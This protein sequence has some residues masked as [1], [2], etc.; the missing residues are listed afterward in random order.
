MGQKQSRVRSKQRGKQ[1]YQ[2]DQMLQQ[3]QY[4]PASMGA[5]PG[6]Y[7]QM[8]GF[9]GGSQDF[10]GGMP[11]YGNQ[12]GNNFYERGPFDYPAAIDYEDM[13][14][15]YTYRSPGPGYGGNIDYYDVGDYGSGGE[16]IPV[17]Q[18]SYYPQGQ[19]Y[20][21]QRP[22]AM[23][24]RMN[25]MK[26]G[27]YSGIG[28]V[29]RNPNLVEKGQMLKQSGKTQTAAAKAVK[30]SRGTG[31]G[32]GGYAQGSAPYEPSTRAVMP[33]AASTAAVPVSFR[34]VQQPVNAASVGPQIIDNPAAL[35]SNFDE[36]QRIGE[37][38]TI[39]AVSF[40]RLEPNPSAQGGS[41]QPME[42]NL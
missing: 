23:R 6:P 4:M 19:G 21:E 3:P 22:S 18:S 1:Y 10:R 38:V 42:T 25:Q 37:Q 35:S 17:Q 41:A 14:P 34:Q 31:M 8:G 39:E 40:T 26:G 11:D 7:Q 5:G 33:P 15:S 2:R 13:Q 9:T 24:G 29:V 12:G 20:G 16:V 36:G 30:G 27:Y 32:T 28:K